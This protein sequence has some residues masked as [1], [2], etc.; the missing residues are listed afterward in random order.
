MEKKF[1]FRK[2]LTTS[3]TPISNAF[4][5]KAENEISLLCGVEFFGDSSKVIEHAKKDF[6]NY[7]KVGFGIK[8]NGE[9]PI[10]ITIKLT[11]SGLED[12]CEY[13]GRIVEIKDSEIFIYA[14]DERGV[15]QA[16]YDLEDKM[17][18]KKVPY[19]DM[20]KSKNK[21]LFSPR[22]THSAYDFDV[23]PEGYLQRLAKEGID[24]IMLSI[25]GVNQ[26]TART[27][28]INAII[29][30]AEEYGIDVYAYF[31]EHVFHNPEADDAEEVY[32]KVMGEV[33]RVHNKLKGIIFVGEIIN[34]PSN[35]DNT[36]KREW[37]KWFNE[38]N[39]P[40]P[41][42]APGFWPCKDFPK[43]I[44]VVKKV[45]RK[46]KADADIVFW[47]YNWGWAP[48]KDRV[49]LLENIPT[50]ITLLVTF[51][52][53]ENIPTN[54]GIT[55]RICD[56]SI[57]FE[58]PSQ[59]FVSEAEVAKRR[60]IRL[61]TQA[62]AGGRTWDFGCLPF[63]PFAQQWLRRYKALRDCN[64]KYNLTGIMESHQYGFWPSFITKIEQK[65]FNYVRESDEQILQSVV[66]E[67]S[68][69]ET[70]KCLQAFE[71][72]SQ[73]IRLYMPTE[74]EQY[75]AMRVGPAY[76]LQLGAFPKPPA[77]LPNRSPFADGF[78]MEYGGFALA[79]NGP[80]GKFTLHA[81]R[82][83]AE[84]QMLKDI[85]KL[86]KKGIDIFA[87]I[88]KKSKEI[89]KLINMGKYMIC[90]F[91]TDIHVKQMYIYR[92]R[93]SVVPTRLEAT[94]LIENIKK[95]AIKEIK[96]C[97]RAIKVVDKDSALGYEP[98]MGYAGDRVH[99][100]WKIRQVKH[101]LEN[102]LSIR[103]KGLKF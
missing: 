61:Y 53:F 17:T 91:T 39:L 103:E 45:I 23:Y 81:I 14:Y 28:D 3:N 75:G 82:I 22:M 5:D 70:E 37:W 90:C 7:L 94:R 33:F 67:F 31:C 78:V 1:K 20:G 13:K 9:N 93:L 42:P 49:E 52:M 4:R 79:L 25:K 99:I 69:G 66:D 63:E 84:I 24:A 18:S 86:L 57:A 48:K 60:G 30:L 76:P 65:A 87:S 46:Q 89:L 73:A 29:D 16:I 34:F 26:T 44:N 41:K 59:V 50:D 8:N 72:W 12:V 68:N 97:E 95:L 77:N 19:L 21:P 98:C 32:S 2:S 43:W 62:N 88:K 85:I 47:T 101:M 27:C 56:Y 51:E 102:E 80:E 83:R 58:G 71:Y 35:D 6:I 38:D 74:N 15:A 64:E 55:E 40:D 92:Q 100:E 36:T 54:Y 11:Q 10:K 96:N